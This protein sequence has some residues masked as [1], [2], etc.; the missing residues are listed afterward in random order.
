MNRVKT[1]LRLIGI[2]VLSIAFVRGVKETEHAIPPVAPVAVAP[3]RQP[4]HVTENPPSQRSKPSIDD[5]RSRLRFGMS[6]DV[7]RRMFADFRIKETIS[8][9][10]S[11]TDFY[12]IDLDPIDVLA[13][14]YDRDQST[15]CHDCVLHEE[16]NVSFEDVLKTLDVEMTEKD[17]NDGCSAFNRLNQTQQDW[18]SLDRNA[19][20]W[21]NRYESIL[22]AGTLA[23]AYRGRWKEVVRAKFEPTVVG[24]PATPL[25]EQPKVVFESIDSPH[26]QTDQTVLDPPDQLRSIP[27]LQVPGEIPADQFRPVP[28]YDNSSPPTYS[29]T[30]APP[31]LHA[32]LIEEIARDA[33]FGETLKVQ[34][35]V[36]D[37]LYFDF[38]PI[39]VYNQ[40]EEEDG[41]RGVRTDDLFPD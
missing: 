4:S 10:T 35:A 39:R 32:L 29:L 38:P 14:T 34:S 12:Q 15:Y 21:I 28:M 26:E 31:L 36:D 18:Y 25:L 13:V 33:I 41:G 8:D 16:S 22:S 17:W 9:A 20:D 2:V 37:G 19:A 5:I 27:V 24:R 23:P 30:N 11:I 7:V 3:P 1:P 6:M 40:T